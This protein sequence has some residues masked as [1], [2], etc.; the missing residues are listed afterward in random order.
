MKND[1]PLHALRAF[2][3][4]AR[5]L[6]FTKAGLELYVSQ[7]AVSQQVR[8]LEEKLVIIL[9]KRLPRGLEMTDEARMLFASITDEFQKI[10]KAHR[11]FEGGSVKESLTLSCVGTFALGWLLPKIEKF[12]N[13]HPSVEINIQTNNNVVNVAGE[14]I[15]FAIR[16]G[17]GNW[18]QTHN[19]LLIN[20]PLTVLCRPDT[21]KRLRNP[22]DIS[23]E[24]L[25]RSYRADEWDG[26]FTAA[27]VNPVRANGPVFDSSR[28]IIDAV[29]LT[30]GIALVSDVMFYHEINRGLIVRPFDIYAG[31]DGYW[32]TWQRTR[33]MTQTMQIFQEWIQGEIDH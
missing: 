15:D 28:L 26:W 10:E 7:A 1:I 19:Q 6:N 8:L 25:L 22:S 11:R 31:N 12:R 13:L 16:Y 23:G 32:L 21:A 33:K 4:Y 27:N 5:H 30:G 17:S 9:F 18:I 2:E 14:G 29:I 20:A 24:K 3:S